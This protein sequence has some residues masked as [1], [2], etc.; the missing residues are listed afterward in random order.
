M[1]SKKISISS[2]PIAIVRKGTEHGESPRLNTERDWAYLGD[3]DSSWGASGLVLKL[4]TRATRGKTEETLKK[5]VGAPHLV[6]EPLL[7]ID[8]RNSSQGVLGE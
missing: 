4:G 3:Q 8:L 2:G 1:A 7:W 6:S 5:Q